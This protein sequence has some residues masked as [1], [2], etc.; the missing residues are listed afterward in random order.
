[1]NIISSQRQHNHLMKLFIKFLVSLLNAAAYQCHTFPSYFF[2]PFLH[3]HTINLPYLSFIFIFV[4]VFVKSCYPLQ[5]YRRSWIIFAMIYAQ[6][7]NRNTWKTWFISLYLFTFLRGR[8]GGSRFFLCVFGYT[9]TFFF[10]NITWKG[11][12]F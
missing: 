5:F 4:F 8:E 6:F 9:M 7:R 11:D 10:H 2:I 12:I 1:M 3:F